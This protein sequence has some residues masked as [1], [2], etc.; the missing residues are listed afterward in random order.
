MADGATVPRTRSLAGA[1]DGRSV[2]TDQY[3]LGVCALLGAIAAPELAGYNHGTNSLFG[4]VVG[5]VQPRAVEEGEHRIPFPPQMDTPLYPPSATLAPARVNMKLDP[6][7]P[8][9]PSVGAWGF[10]RPSGTA[11]R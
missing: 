3:A 5:R 6:F 7:H 10:F 1:V 11:L 9:Y 4:P 2:D 8:R